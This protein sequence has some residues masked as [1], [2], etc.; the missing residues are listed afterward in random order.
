MRYETNANTSTLSFV[1]L[2]VCVCGLT[3]GLPPCNDLQVDKSR[4]RHSTREYTALPSVL[5]T[6][7]PNALAVMGSM[8]SS[9][10]KCCGRGRGVYLS[11]T[12]QGQGQAAGCGLSGSVKWGIFFDYLRNIFDFQKDS[13][14]IKVTGLFVCFVFFSP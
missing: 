12:G 14:P 6:I 2:C 1:S 4:G 11:I 10:V 8:C 3:S 5:F 7:L 13:Y 9:V